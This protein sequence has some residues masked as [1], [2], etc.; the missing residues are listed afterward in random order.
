MSAALVRAGAGGEH[1]G[2]ALVVMRRQ[3]VDALVD[4]AE[5]QIVRRQYQNVGRQRARSFSANAR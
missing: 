1:L 4:A 5:R 2:A 3:L